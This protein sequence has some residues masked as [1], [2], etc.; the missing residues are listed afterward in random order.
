M[1]VQGGDGFGKTFALLVE[2]SHERSHIVMEVYGNICTTDPWAALTHGI[3]AVWTMCAEYPG[4]RSRAF[5]TCPS[6]EKR[7]Q[8]SNTVSIFDR[9]YARG[10]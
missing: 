3:S 7:M 2:Y 6:H 1:L 8:I 5:L 9:R 10:E 4:L